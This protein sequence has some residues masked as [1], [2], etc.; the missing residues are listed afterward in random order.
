M[1]K[2]ILMALLMYSTNSYA[3]ITCS[4]LD[5]ASVYS[6][7]AQPRYLGFLGSRFATDSIMN[8]FGNYGSRFAVD[9]VRNQFGTYGSQFNSLSATNT[10]TSTPP[11][12]FKNNQIIGYLTA[13]TFL[14]GGVSL[15][16]IDASCTFNSSTVAVSVPS[17]LSG[18]LSIPGETS[19][20]LIWLSATGATR[21]DVYVALSENGAKTFLQSTTTTS[22]I[23]TG[24]AP[25]TV[26]YFFVYPANSA[27]SGN[28]MWVSASTIPAAN[29]SPTVSIVGGNRTVADTN[30]QAGETVSL[31]GTATDTDGTIASTQWLV[32]GIVVATGT[33]ASLA[34]P[35]GVTLVTFRATDEDGASA[36]TTSTITVTAAVI[37]NKSP[38]VSIVGGNR[39]VTDT[40]QLA[41]ETVSLTGTA[42][43]TDGT[44]ANTQWLVN[45]SVVATGTSASLALPDG[46]TVVTFR[47]S[48]DDGASST[49]TATITVT[50]PVIANKPPTV[51]IVGGNRTV[52]DTNQ[53]AGETVSPTGTATDTDGTIANTLW[54]INGSV[55][56]TGTSAS[57][58]LS[59]G[60]TVVSFRA[61]DEDG[62]SA[63]TP[64]TITVTAAV[65]ANKPPTVSIVGGN[66]TVADTN[67]LAGET[68][69]LTGTATDT[70]GTIASTQW[71]M[72][73]VVVA[74]GTS[75]SLALPDGVSVVTFRATDEDGASATTTATITIE[76]MTSTQPLWLGTYNTIAAPR[77]FKLDFNSIGNI[78]LHRQQLHSCVRIL[79]KGAPSN[80][81]GMSHIDV[82]FKIVSLDAGIIRLIG[83][84]DF[85]AQSL[86][87]GQNQVAL[88]DCSGRFETSTGEY[89]DVI[90]LGD[91]LF[92][93]TFKLTD[94]TQ[95][96]FI[97]VGGTEIVAE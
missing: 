1:K 46:V 64:A 54:L 66:R 32:N 41:G 80:V 52:A 50:A 88:P 72:N 51:S 11:A 86:G 96:E 87:Q 69:S 89:R 37:A 77:G 14:S 78:V 18:L 63:T 17:P 58:A 92:D 67:Q 43:D 44:I 45:G 81:D 31:T 76:T 68:V 13:N 4:I 35:D 95:L 75:A 57:L 3:Q 10:F 40:N 34:L 8:Q 19:I 97:L 30:Q 38:T 20:G 53:L 59:D 91:Q 36:T 15:A 2:I 61:T 73:G 83:A 60:V 79:A 48:D 7:E 47:A 65:I 33:S 93:A 49:T 22:F 9:S 28:G 16:Q 70:D 94:E 42:T 55:V 84:R 71:L 12:I 5:G 39:T 26:Y 85:R 24:A 82:T 74:T 21:Y 6:N 25:N 23:A 90:K 27:G 62:A 29:K 56:A